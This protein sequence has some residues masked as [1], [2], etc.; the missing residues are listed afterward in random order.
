MADFASFVQGLEADLNSNSNSN[1]TRKLLLISTHSNQASGYAKVSHGLIRE[2]ATTPGLQITHFAIQASTT[3]DFKRTYPSSVQVIDAGTADQGFGFQEIASVIQR[4]QPHV[5]LIYN[6]IGVCCQ[7][8]E[9]IV[10]LRQGAKGLTFQIWLYLDQVYECQMPQ[11]LE[12][13]QKETDRIFCFTQEWRSVLKNQGI[14]RPIDVLQ[15]GFDSS[16]FPIVSKEEARAK[17]GI[18]KETFLFLSANRN[19][20]RKRLDLLVMAFAELVL[21]HPTKPLFLLCVCDKGEKGGF[22]LYEIFQRELQIRGS[23]MEPFANRLIITP[24]EMTYMDAEIGQLYQIADV[25]LS[26][27]DGEGFGLCAFEQMGLGIP[28]VLSNVVGHRDYCTAENSQLVDV[29]YRS[30]LPLCTSVLGGQTTLV[31]PP[32][33]AKAMERYVLDEDLRLKHGLEA[34][35]TVATYTWSRVVET[36]RKRLLQ[37]DL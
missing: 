22:P 35:K 2:L 6:D 30:Y 19:Q 28:Q 9:K 23:P 34:K 1:N 5:V 8:L 4:V 13:V 25:G 26:T 31:Y 17:L 7:Y 36:L 37:I 11:F 20:P 18:P 27:A 24:R 15:H 29:V 32:S 14:T 12:L 10:P 21:M 33:F 3:V 16:L